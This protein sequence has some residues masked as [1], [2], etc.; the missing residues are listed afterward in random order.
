MSSFSL[1]TAQLRSEVSQLENVGGS[2]ER[3]R[4]RVSWARTSLTLTGQA[5]SSVD[6]SLSAVMKALSKQSSQ[7]TDVSSALAQ[8]AARYDEAENSAASGARAAVNPA[9]DRV[10]QGEPSQYEP[11]WM[12]RFFEFWGDLSKWRIPS[13]PINVVNYIVAR[14]LVEYM[15][16]IRHEKEQRDSAAAYHYNSELFDDEGGYGGNQGYMANY[17]SDEEK[18]HYINQVMERYPGMSRQEAEDLLSVFNRNGCAYT[19]LANTLLMQYEGRQKE[20]EET[21]GIPYYDKNGEVNYNDLLLDLYITTEQSGVN[22]PT[23]G[24]KRSENTVDGHVMPKGIDEAG[25]STVMYN[26]LENKGVSEGV[27]TATKKSMTLEEC[28]QEVTEG[29]QVVIMLRDDVIS[30]ESDPNHH[31]NGHAMVV[32]GIKDGKYEVSSWGETYYIDPAHL[33]ENDSFVIMDYDL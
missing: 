7:A 24:T 1:D 28:R 5:A 19:A 20:F 12:E 3:L 6:R 9:A 26:Y 18:E 10:V 16:R 2:L 25:M 14:A 23:D 4:G 11:G 27:S 32:T 31:I 17:A 21:F 30:N 15:R 8:I 13:A 29:K 22:I 33:D